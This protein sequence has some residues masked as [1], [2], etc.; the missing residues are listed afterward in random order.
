M[1]RAS[2]KETLLLPRHTGM[3]KGLACAEAIPRDLRSL[4]EFRKLLDAVCAVAATVG[5]WKAKHRRGEK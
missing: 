3:D 4:T 2:D 1:T 5:G